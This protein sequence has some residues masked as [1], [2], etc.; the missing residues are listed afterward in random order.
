M[1]FYIKLRKEL[2]NKIPDKELDLLPRSYNMLGDIMI[3]KLKSEKHK[4]EIADSILK[5]NPSAKTIILDRGISGIKR[6]PNIEI[7]A[8]EKKTITMHKEHGMNFW[9]DV[10]KTMWS[11]GNKFEKQRLAGLVKKNEVVVDM[12]AGIGYWTV[13]VAKRAKKVYAIDI[14]KD[15][16]EFLEKNIILNNLNNVEVLQGDCRKF[17]KLLENTADRVIM[18]YIY[19]TEKFLPTA[20]KIAKKKAIIHFHRITDDP[21][22]IKKKLNKYGTV[23]YRL[24]KEYAPKIGHYV[25]DIKTL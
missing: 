8:G 24:V 25:F 6:K 22:K 5:I 17:S 16:I 3:I 19:E 4:K 23:S 11:K 13:F 18:G 20:L 14:N 12:F 21:E 9:I 1:S 15:A 10:S 7:L 2:E